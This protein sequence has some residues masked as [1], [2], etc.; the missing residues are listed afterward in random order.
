MLPL[1]FKEYLKTKDKYYLCDIGLKRLNYE[2]YVG[3][4]EDKEVDFIIK[5]NDGIKYIITL[6]Y[7]TN[8]YNGIK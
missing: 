3:K 6:D 2:I 8:N 5:D 4:F 7:D 1:S